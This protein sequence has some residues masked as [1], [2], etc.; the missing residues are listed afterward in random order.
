MFGKLSPKVSK[1]YILPENT[2]IATI[3][4][5]NIVKYAKEAIKFVELPKYPAVERDIA[6]IVERDILSFD[7]QK[8]I[9]NV[10]SNIIENVELFDVY[11]GEQIEQGK[12]SMA[13]RIR[14]RSNEKTLEENEILSIMID[15]NSLLENKF[16]VIFRK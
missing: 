6:F 15:I 5:D 1:N 4:F 13:Y 11:Q 12:K 14:L 8:A 9:K 3:E 16:N 10:R 2:Y 7:I